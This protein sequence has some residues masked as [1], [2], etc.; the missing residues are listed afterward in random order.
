MNW[1]LFF[2][3]VLAYFLYKKISPKIKKWFDRGDP[4]L[5]PYFYRSAIEDAFSAYE[6]LDKRTWNLVEEVTKMDDHG[7]KDLSKNAEYVKLYKELIKVR[8]A[9]NIYFE[10][11]EYMIHTNFKVLSGVSTNDVEDKYDNS[12]MYERFKKEVETDFKEHGWE[13]TRSDIDLPD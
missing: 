10:K 3:S 11:Y 13:C 5:Y 2:M 1:S 7:K 8:S 12:E 9:K 6:K 4:M